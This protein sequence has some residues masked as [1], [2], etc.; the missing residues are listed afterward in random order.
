M[1]REWKWTQM[2]GTLK[3]EVGEKTKKKGVIEERERRKKKK[4]RRKRKREKKEEEIKIIYWNVAGI[5]SMDEKGWEFIKEADIIAMTE[6]WWDDKRESE[7]ARKLIQK[8]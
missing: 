7:N 3:V 1:E 5:K 2:K 4:S 6:T 8:S